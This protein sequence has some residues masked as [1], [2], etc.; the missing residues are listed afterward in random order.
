MSKNPDL[1]DLMITVQEQGS[2]E[3]QI[4]PMVS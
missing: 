4:T 2:E 3:A 1:V